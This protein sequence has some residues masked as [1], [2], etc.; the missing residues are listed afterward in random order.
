MRVRPGEFGANRPRGLELLLLTATHF[1][2]FSSP[3]ALVVAALGEWQSIRSWL[4]YA[5]AGIGIA[6]AG[7]LAQYSS[8]SGGPT[9]LNDYAMAFFTPGVIAGLVY[10]ILAGRHAGEDPDTPRLGIATNGNSGATNDLVVLQCNKC[11]AAPKKVLSSM[12]RERLKPM[13]NADLQSRFA[14]SYLDAMNGYMAASK[15]ASNAIMGNVFDFWASAAK[16]M[17]AETPGTGVRPCCR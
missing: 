10:W 15:A 7:F 6:I 14:K 11:V 1:A 8:E 4:Y 5:V 16:T 17:A 3:F 12:R 9:I 13:Y 2:V